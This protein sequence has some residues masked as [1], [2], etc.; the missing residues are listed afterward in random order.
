MEYKLIELNKG[1][2]IVNGNLIHSSY[3]A[4]AVLNN[5]ELIGLVLEKDNGIK[6][7]SNL[8]D[9]K[10]ELKEL[11]NEHG[12]KPTIISILPRHEIIEDKDLILTMVSACIISHYGIDK[13]HRLYIDQYGEYWYEIIDS[14]MKTSE[15]LKY[16]KMIKKL[17]REVMV[18]V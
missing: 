6:L 8:A 5:N 7:I 3:N 14:L 1:I 12:Y 11:L 9:N 16:K 15:L 13:I 18:V 4:I 17:K 10:K 2:D